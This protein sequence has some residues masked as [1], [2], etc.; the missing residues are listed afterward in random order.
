[1]TNELHVLNKWLEYPYW[2]KGQTTEM[3]LFHECLLLLIRANGN[4]MLDQG[5]IRDYIKSS[6]EGTLDKETVDRE[7]EKYSYLAQEISEFISNTKL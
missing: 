1:M 2:Y 6:K 5:D 7:A 4:Q 3:K